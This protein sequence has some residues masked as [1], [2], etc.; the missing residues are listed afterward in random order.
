MPRAVYVALALAML[1][2]RIGAPVALAL[3]IGF[4][5]IIG[6]PWDGRIAGLS[7]RLLKICVVGLG[8][9]LPLGTVVES[10]LDG[11]WMT[12]LSVVSI[13]VAGMVLARR[14]GMD[15]NCGS[16]ISAGTAICGG[17]AIAAVAPVLGAR[18]AAISMALACVFV[19]NAVALYLFPAIGHALDLS[20]SEF[21]VWAAIAIHDTSSVV[22]AASSYGDAALAEATVLKLA[23]ALWIV[24]LVAVFTWLRTDADG[25][26]GPITWPIFVG[27][28]VLAAAARSILPE[29]ETTFD[30]AAGAARRGLVLVLFLIGSA[31]TPAV[32]RRLGWHALLFSTTLWL[33][34]SAVTL[35]AVVLC[36]AD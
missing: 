4:A 9:G 27:L 15:G 26:A 21:A 28:F 6:D 3:G 5:F 12:G 35:V 1:W 2:P 31:L 24:P 16:L 23:R 8:F 32:L 19:L 11:L 14:F 25:R 36:P 34:V 29:F 33:L 30:Q 13:L 17:S 10:G 22:G 18:P 20:Q 7:G